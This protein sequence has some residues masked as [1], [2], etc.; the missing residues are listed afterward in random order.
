[1]SEARQLPD[2]HGP[3][4]VTIPHMDD[5]VIGCGALLA[6][7]PDKRD[8]HFF[9]CGDGLGSFTSGFLRAYGREKLMAL[10][11][12]EALSALAAL[13][14]ANPDVTFA[15]MEEWRYRQNQDQ[16]RS[17]LNA[18]LDQVNPKVVLTPFRMDCHRDHLALSQIARDWVARRPDVLGLE[19][20][21]YFHLRLLP[22]GDMRRQI[23]PEY[24][25]VADTRPFSAL[26]KKA[27]AAYVSQATLFDPAWVKPVLSD[28]FIQQVAHG[29]EVFFQTCKV[30]TGKKWLMQPA[31]TRL[32]HYLEPRL[33]KFKDLMG[34]RIQQNL[35]T[36]R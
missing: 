9:F 12:A 13:G 36:S 16:L 10:R 32:V 4:A 33:K 20:F 2:L 26:K 23:A 21:V 5:E 15:D 31:R 14:Y 25:F 7:I 1:M 34:M 27:L 6:S 3:V 24:L 17:H 19:Y 30:Q 8:V 18:W 35:R 29:E 28:G 11:K 22:K